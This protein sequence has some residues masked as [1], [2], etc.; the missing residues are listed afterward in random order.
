[1]FEKVL[2]LV[3]LGT[4]IIITG[5]I[6]LLTSKDLQWTPP[7]WGDYM[8]IIGAI[9]SVC[10]IYVVTQGQIKVQ[11]QQFDKEHQLQI[12]AFDR[13]EFIQALDLMS[14]KNTFNIKAGLTSMITLAFY[15]ESRKI[16]RDAHRALNEFIKKIALKSTCPDNVSASELIRFI[17]IQFENTNFELR[18]NEYDHTQFTIQGVYFEEIDFSGLNITAFNFWNTEFIRCNFS[19]C[20]IYNPSIAMKFHFENCEMTGFAMQR[21]VATPTQN[22]CFVSNKD[23]QPQRIDLRQVTTP[24]FDVTLPTNL[25]WNWSP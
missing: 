24:L 14:S 2:Q 12:H 17:F 11:Q 6:G 21:F 18:D 9:V 10:G 16:Q 23:L 4:F 20:L 22:N 8:A 13:Q 25:S 3:L 1:M 7:D 19:G 5:F 15:Q